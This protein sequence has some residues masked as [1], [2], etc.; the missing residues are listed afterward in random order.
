[1]FQESVSEAISKVLQTPLSK[2]ELAHEEEA[3]LQLRLIKSAVMAGLD[4]L[5]QSVAF[6]PQCGATAPV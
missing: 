4:S 2:D 3:V 1:M 6:F 5:D